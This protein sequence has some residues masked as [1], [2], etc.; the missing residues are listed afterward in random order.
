VPGI[1]LNPATVSVEVPISQ[2][3]TYKEVGIRPVIRGRLK[4]GY[5][6]EPVEVNPPSV[7][8][9][10]EPA[11][12]A[13]I[14]L[15]ETEPVDVTDLAATVVRQVALRAPARASILQTQNRPVSVTLRVSPLQTTQTLQ[16]APTVAN[17][18]PELAVAEPPGL[19]EL[20][21]SGP[22]PILQGL[23]PQDFRVVLDAS[24]LNVGS[25]LVEPRV[26]LPSGFQ[27]VSINPAR[28]RL[29]IRPAG[30]EGG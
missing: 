6:L 4:A 15:V 3:V 18:R 27:L 5:Y 19:V 26:E 16:V 10:G 11:A 13:G 7:T 9:V 29:T 2:S 12:L 24:S 8:V 22:A 17:L 20:T 21:I 25:Q 28:V 1:R 23:K 14:T 30:G